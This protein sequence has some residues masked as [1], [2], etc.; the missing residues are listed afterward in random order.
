MET[1]DVLLLM[2]YCRAKKK[3]EKKPREWDWTKRRNILTSQIRPNWIRIS[4]IKRQKSC[5][6]CE[7]LHRNVK[8]SGKCGNAWQKI[9][10]AVNGCVGWCKRNW[11]N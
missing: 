3:L 1:N 11:M 9:C 6:H 7:N 2:N 4:K 8:P 5:P 10:V